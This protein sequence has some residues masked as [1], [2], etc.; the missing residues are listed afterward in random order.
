MNRDHPTVSNASFYSTSSHHKLPK[1]I[2]PAFDGSIL[3]W[4]TFWDSFESSVH[5]NT[6]LSD[7]QKFSYLKSQLEGS[8]TMTVE[9]F[10]LTHGNCSRA[11]DLLREGYGQHHKIIHATMQALLQLPSPSINI[12]SLRSFYDKM[13]SYV[14]GLESLNQN[15]ETYGSLLVPI[16]LDK[17]PN[18][19]RKNLAREN[20]HNNWNLI[21]LRRAIDREINILEAGNSS[22]NLME[23]TATAMFHTQSKDRFTRNS[24]KTEKSVVKCAYYDKNHYS[25]ECKEFGNLD[26]R[27]KQVK[28]NKLL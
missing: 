28:Q 27:M 4:Q 20:E 23:Q 5:D 16:L 1:L 12:P 10:S 3:Q 24:N 7:V 13:E 2:L 19:L 25:N 14:C 15:Q 6:N 18:E 26:S 17:L 9:G 21:N 8:A 11:I 22:T